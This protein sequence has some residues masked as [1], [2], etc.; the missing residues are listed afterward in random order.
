MTTPQLPDTREIEMKFTAA[1]PWVLH[2]ADEI[3][4]MN[5]DEPKARRRYTSHLH[6]Y[7]TPKLKL[8]QHGVLL[9]TLDAN[10]PHF[11][12]RIQ[13]KTAGRANPNSLMIRTEFNLSAQ[14]N[15]LRLQDIKG[16]PANA[17]LNP[18]KRSSLK[19]WFTTVTDRTEL[20]A[21]YV[22]GGKSVM[23]ECSLDQIIFQRADDNMQ[24]RSGCE[25]ELEVKTKYSDPT[26]T[27]AE[28]QAAIRHV[29]NIMVKALPHLKVN[30]QSRADMGFGDLSPKAAIPA[31]GGK[32]PR[33]SIPL[34]NNRKFR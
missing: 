3:F 33:P 34:K 15:G 1:A 7:D 32:K 11:N 22:V 10:E 6:Y 20:R 24:F 13:I 21:I 18:V 4:L 16:H 5:A 2:K 30:T 25:V 26:L 12:S 28:A 23:I 27:D 14:G 29:A 17:F 9:R 31:R 8:R 19:H